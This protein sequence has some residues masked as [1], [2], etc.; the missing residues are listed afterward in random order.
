MPS[1]IEAWFE[2]VADDRVAI[3]EEGLEEATVGVEAG[4]VE[5]RVLHPQVAGKRGLELLVRVLGAADESH[6]GQAI[7]VD[8]ERGARSRHD[9]R[10]RAQAKVVIRTEIEYGSVLSA[11]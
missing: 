1:M 7:A 10:V 8:I 5:D 6:A 2:G 11:T 9:A 4:R 3:V